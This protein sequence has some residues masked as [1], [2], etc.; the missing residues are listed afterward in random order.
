MSSVYAFTSLHDCVV[1]F[2]YLKILSVS[3]E[4]KDEEMPNFAVS[5][6]EFFSG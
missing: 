6:W 5:H 2:F 3:D 1:F 4:E